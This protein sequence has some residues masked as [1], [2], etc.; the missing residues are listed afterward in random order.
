MLSVK[1][2]RPGGCFRQQ[3]T[4]AVPEELVERRHDET[5]C[6]VAF[7]EIIDLGGMYIGAG[8]MG[9]IV[10]AHAIGKYDVLMT[11]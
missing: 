10:G 9:L 11:A 8:S 5:D 6:V 1:V 2:V 7:H 4:G 3:L